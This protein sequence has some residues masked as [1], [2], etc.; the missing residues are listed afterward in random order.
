MK[1]GQ[2]LFNASHK[3]K[4]SC[5]YCLLTY[6]A[7]YKKDINLRLSSPSGKCESIQIPK[8]ELL[9]LAACLE[10]VLQAPLCLNPAFF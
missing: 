10:Q 8:P 2:G 5:K 9:H 1:N 4:L 3:S 6:T 7:L